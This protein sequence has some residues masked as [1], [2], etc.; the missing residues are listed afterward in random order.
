MAGILFKPQAERD[1]NLVILFPSDPGQVVIKDAET[2]EVIGTGSNSGPSNN[3]GATIRFDKPGSAYNNVIIETAN[4]ESFFIDDGSVRREN[5]DL[6]PAGTTPTAPT[7]LPS[8]GGGEGGAGGLDPTVA[9]VAPPIFIDPNF[10]QPFPVE[11]PTIPQANFQFTDPL[12]FTGEVA[13]FNRG[14]TAQAFEVGLER[15]K[16]L[17]EEE[18]ES[19]IN[20]AGRISE[21][22]QGL[23]EGENAFNQLQ[24][25]QAA[26]TAIPGVQGI[27][28]RQR[29]RAET[30]AEGRL[31]TTAE[32]R[33]F[34][35]A[36]RSASAEGSFIRGF[37]DDSVVGARQ[38]EI[39][40][41]Q[42]RLGLTQLGEN[43][44]SR[45]I[46]QAAGI[47]M[48]Q[49]L[50]A[51]IS[52]RLPSQPNVPL[53]TLATTQQQIETGLTTI[54]PQAALSAE[55]QQ[56]QFATNLEQRTNEFNAAGLFN[57]QTF[58]SSQFF[59]ALLQ[60]LGINLFNAQ[61][62][63]NFQQ[64]VLNV[65]AE[66]AQI[67]EYRRLR[68]EL[69]AQFERNRDRQQLANA[70]GTIFGG[71][72]RVP[73]SVWEDIFGAVGDAASTLIDFVEEQTGIDFGFGDDGTDEIVET[74]PPPGE[75]VATGPEGETIDSEG[76]VV[77]TVP[78]A[79]EG[80]ASAPGE[81]GEGTVIDSEGNEVSAT[82]DL[83]PEQRSAV[84]TFDPTTGQLLINS[85][86][87]LQQENVNPDP[88]FR[89]FRTT[90]TIQLTQGQLE[91]FR[92]LI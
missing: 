74:I 72:S 50:K 51:N 42:Q 33:A 14:Q 90:A 49:P 27:F 73:R 29:E 77:E 86:N 19:I 47:L 13:E 35:E 39:L 2:K 85:V 69:L 55:I 20:F 71:I 52:Q 56:Q 60:Q 59:N 37:G 30:L 88:L 76:N 45:S 92:G 44:L 80:V 66:S 70:L 53:S 43:F 36:A 82:E 15:A 84:I 6:S 89:E 34:E 48:D 21:F 64:G 65:Q 7:G 57:A 28:E 8:Q 78:P 58:N 23:L 61:Q 91:A 62:L 17:Q 4:G 18:L 40:S 54:Q 1:G 38:S 11:F 63:Q 67:E 5:I 31:L 68:E 83:P 26:E 46:Q 16:T 87:V 32:D 22:Q 79:G 41:A 25:L 10:I 81:D 75:G 12:E 9:G 3:F 24:R